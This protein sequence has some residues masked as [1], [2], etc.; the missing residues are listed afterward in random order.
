MTQKIKVHVDTG[1]ANGTHT[2][3]W[4]LPDCWESMNDEEKQKFIN[5]C[6]EDFLH[7]TC[8]CYAELVESD[9]E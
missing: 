2:D 4:D 3:Y 9:D 8:E 6:A 7:E 5:E 1:W